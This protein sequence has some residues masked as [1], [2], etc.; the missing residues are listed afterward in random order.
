[1]HSLSCSITEASAWVSWK[2]ANDCTVIFLNALKQCLLTFVDG[3]YAYL[4]TL[5]LS[6]SLQFCLILHFL[7][8]QSLT[9]SQNQEIRAFSSVSW[10]CTQCTCIQPS[11]LLAICWSF[12]TAPMGISFSSGFFLQHFGQLIFANS[13]LLLRQL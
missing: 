9:V 13:Y 1:M 10:A 8:M 4:G 11:R 12:L 5:Q 7:L 3:L 2:S 6:C